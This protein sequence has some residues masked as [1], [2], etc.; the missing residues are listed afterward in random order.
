MKITIT[1]VRSIRFSTVERGRNGRP[2]KVRNSKPIISASR[3]A[4]EWARVMN[5]DW[6]YRTF[7]VPNGDDDAWDYMSDADFKRSEEREKRIYR[8][9][10][11]IFQRMLDAR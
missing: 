2:D 10:L 3:A 9:V 6:E 11:P 4:E 7:A 5:D 1:P 8:R